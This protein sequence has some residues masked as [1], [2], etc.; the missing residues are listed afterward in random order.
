MEAG[1]R[2]GTEEVGAVVVVA[3]VDVDMVVMAG[4]E[5]KV[6]HVVVAARKAVPWV[7]RIHGACLLGGGG[8]DGRRVGGDD[9]RGWFERKP[10]FARAKVGRSR[11]KMVIGLNTD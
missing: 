3:E 8:R 2:R 9:I 6:E 11:I 4:V 1:R 10:A 5:V 7:R